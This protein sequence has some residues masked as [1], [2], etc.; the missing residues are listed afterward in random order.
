ML[1]CDSCDNGYHLD[2]L[3]PVLDEIPIGEWYC[4]ECIQESQ[5]ESKNED[6]E[7]VV[8][9]L[10]EIE[11]STSNCVQTRTRCSRTTAATT[12]NYRQI[13][14]TR[15]SERIRRRINNNRLERGNSIVISETE[16]ED[17]ISERKKFNQQCH[18]LV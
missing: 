17:E 15:F 1:L 13:A 16:E 10:P 8:Y 12:A 18:H 7:E 6:D 11:I 14:R 4:V 9:D 3:N 2:C 5:N